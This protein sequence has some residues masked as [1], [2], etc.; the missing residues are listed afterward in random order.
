MSLPFSEL[1]IFFLITK[2][3]GF[4]HIGF[5]SDELYFNLPGL[6]IQI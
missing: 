2:Q 3:T 5:L 6:E 4:Y 1:L